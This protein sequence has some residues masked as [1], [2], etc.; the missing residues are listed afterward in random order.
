MKN[1]RKRL[2]NQPKVNNVQTNGLGNQPKRNNVQ[3]EEVINQ[4]RDFD[5]LERIDFTDMD[6][7]LFYCYVLVEAL[8]DKPM[9]IIISHCL[10]HKTDMR[11]INVQV[12]ESAGGNENMGVI[13]MNFKDS[14]SALC[15][16]VNFDNLLHQI[17]VRI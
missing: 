17:A 11:L 12:M 1:R 5:I 2:G 16:Y 4:P 13:S 10:A 7:I 15:R 14:D 9:M 6:D 8:K 3:N